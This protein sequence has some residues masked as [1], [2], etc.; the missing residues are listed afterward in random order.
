MNLSDLVGFWL[1][2][3]QQLTLD[4]CDMTTYEPLSAPS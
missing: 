3:R 1:G 2:K 4:V